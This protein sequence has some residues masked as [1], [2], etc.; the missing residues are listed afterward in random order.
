MSAQIQFTLFPSA[1][2]A[3]A[4]AWGARGVLALQLPD[5][6]EQ[7][8]EARLR[9]LVAG[10]TRASPP[11][12][13]RRIIE[14]IGALLRGE[15]RDLR[16]ARLDMSALSA[17]QRRV[18]EAARRIE[19]GHTLSYGELA[20][21]CGDRGAA[22]AVGRALGRNPFPI[23]VPCHRVL[24]ARGGSGG[25]SAHGGVTT[26]LRLLHLEG[27]T[28]GNSLSLPFGRPQIVPPGLPA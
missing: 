6:D 10:G 11:P 15:P 9:R 8:T 18:Y 14:D 20:A 5:A 19:P 7:R 26:K 3:C 22:R 24:G 23:I 12:L 17:F 16:R 28:G 25:F 1:I 2:G 4:I 13:I 21:R 27:W